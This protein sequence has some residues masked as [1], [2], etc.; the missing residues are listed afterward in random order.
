M[1][2]KYY[3]QLAQWKKL[4]LFLMLICFIG[5]IGRLLPYGNEMW[6]FIFENMI[7]F[8]VEAG[9]TIF[10]VDRIIHKNNEKLESIREFNQYYDLANEDLEE[11][12]TSI[13]IQL[14]SAITNTQPEKGK[15]N[16]TFDDICKNIDNYVSIQKLKDGFTAPIIDPTNFIE[17]LQNIRYQ[18]ISF[19]Q[20]M[21]QASNIILSRIDDHFSIFLKYIPVELFNILHSIQRFLETSIY[22]SRNENLKFGRDMLLQRESAMTMKDSEYQQTVDIL[23]EFYSTIYQKINK[24]ESIIESN[25]KEISQ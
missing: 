18:R 9:V 17:S 16:D 24:M 3:V 7:W 1:M 8:P 25:K 21:P 20:S 4:F 2:K 14:I 22:F 12:I 5:I 15:V 11:M 19:Y 10:I 6:N 13:K 23:K